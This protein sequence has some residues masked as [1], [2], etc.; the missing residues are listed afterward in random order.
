MI[1]ISAKYGT[2]VSLLKE[3]IG[4]KLFESKIDI[5]LLIPYD[6]GDIV[7]YLCDKCKVEQMDYEENG[8]VVTASLEIDDYRRL[9]KYEIV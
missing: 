4:K 5:K 6:R 2:N 7:S 1:Y 8:T 9:S 3:K